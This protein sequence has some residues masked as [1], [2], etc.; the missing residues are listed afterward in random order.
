M[1]TAQ[2][3]G[4]VAPVDPFTVPSATSPP[5]RPFLASYLGR[6]G[7]ACRWLPANALRVFDVGCASGYGSA[8]V[9]AAGRPAR[10]VVG[11]ERDRDHLEHGWRRLPWL[12]L[13]EGDAA[14]LPV[15][16]ACAPLLSSARPPC[17]RPPGPPLLSLLSHSPLNH[18]LPPPPP[19]SPPPP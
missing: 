12:T 6:T 9:A 15:P 3:R 10:V 13:L 16:D 18:P 1:T 8:G 17:S 7:R 19:P 4:S 11:V 14:A 5:R 2:V